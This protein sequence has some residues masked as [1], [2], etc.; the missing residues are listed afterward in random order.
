ML[1][2]FTLLG[3]MRYI[4]KLTF[5]CSAKSGIPLKM[6]H[7]GGLD[8]DRHYRSGE[9]MT[10]KVRE[11]IGKT[12]IT[13][14]ELYEMFLKFDRKVVQLGMALSCSD[15]ANIKEYGDLADGIIAK[16][17][18]CAVTMLED[19]IPS[20]QKAICGNN[21]TQHEVNLAFLL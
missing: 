1:P 7:S 18:E 12:A 14:K 3:S 2:P 10:E 16:A 11:Y 19:I 5:H 9:V 17:V 8:P 13:T 20:Q 21:F 4:K 6:A 15:T